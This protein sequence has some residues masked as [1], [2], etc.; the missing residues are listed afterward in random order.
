V[1]VRVCVCVCVCVYVV[2]FATER[3]RPTGWYYF[4]STIQENAMKTPKEENDT[5]YFFP[6]R[7][8]YC[9]GACACAC[10]FGLLVRLCICV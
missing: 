6:R 5:Y 8:V 3:R 10:P 4:S 1:C 7:V 2:D 9:L